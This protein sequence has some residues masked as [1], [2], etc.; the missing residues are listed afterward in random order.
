VPLHWR[1]FNGNL[2]IPEIAATNKSGAEGS[3]WGR[4]AKGLGRLSAE[5]DRHP[6]VAGVDQGRLE[7]SAA[8]V[9]GLDR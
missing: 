5:A 9:L 1:I 3:D 2:L 7:D 4:G 6:A 8:K